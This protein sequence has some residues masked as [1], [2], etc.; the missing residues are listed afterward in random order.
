MVFFPNL[1]V[2]LEVQSSNK[3]IFLRL[4]IIAFLDLGKKSSFVCEHSL[5]IG[6]K[7]SF[8]PISLSGSKG[9]PT[10][11]VIFLRLPII[12]FLGLGKKSHL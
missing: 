7:W 2:R 1:F 10:N 3:V 5:P 9:N 11:I 12:A 6:H 4:P 8:S